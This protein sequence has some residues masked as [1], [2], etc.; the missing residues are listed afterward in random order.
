[1]FV[2]EC[3]LLCVVVRLPFVC[4]LIVVIFGCSLLIVVCFC[5]W[6]CFVF[7]VW[8]LLLSVVFEL[9]FVVRWASRNWL[10]VV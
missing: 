1:M 4:L 10:F 3:C 7:A 9:L 6:T 8:C 2:V 5:S